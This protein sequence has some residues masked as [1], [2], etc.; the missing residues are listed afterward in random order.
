MY[1]PPRDSQPGGSDFTAQ[2]ELQGARSNLQTILR[3]LSPMFWG[4]LFAVG[5]RIGAPSLFYLVA[6]G[7]FSVQ[8]LMAKVADALTVT[9]GA[10][11]PKRGPVDSRSS[12]SR[13]ETEN[14]GASPASKAKTVVLETPRG[15]Q[16]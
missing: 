3:I 2:G 12:D 4:R 1:R 10:K 6:A 7:M 8:L 14:T 5:T 13:P 16:L 9:D 15:T 11:A